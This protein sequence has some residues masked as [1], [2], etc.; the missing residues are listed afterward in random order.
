[1]CVCAC[2]ER[3]KGNPPLNCDRAPGK[4][5]KP[6]HYDRRVKLS[7]LSVERKAKRETEKWEE[8]WNT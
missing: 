6:L 8:E 4:R 2:G 1:M 3:G 7:Y 5:A